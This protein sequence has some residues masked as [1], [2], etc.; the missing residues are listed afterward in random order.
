MHK[1]KLQKIILAGLCAAII[2]IGI[3]LFR[4]NLPAVVG[5]PFIHFGNTFAVIA[6][7]ILGFK[8][9][10]C[11]AVLGLGLFDILNG[12]AATSWIT[13]LEAVILAAVT[14]LVFR[15]VHYQNNQVGKVGK[16]Y[17]VSLAAGLIKLVTSWLAGVIE[18]LMVGTHL[19][20]AVINAFLSLPAAAINAGATFIIVPLIYLALEK[21]I[22][23]RMRL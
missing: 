18:S 10:A 8:Y 12:Y 4:I 20:V 22:L 14:A 17:L 11:A 1:V 16:L 13:M 7:M 5:R 23:K 19:S 15:A 9:G 3:S 6:V 21:T 2:F